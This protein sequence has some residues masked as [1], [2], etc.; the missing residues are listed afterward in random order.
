MATPIAQWRTMP[1]TRRTSSSDT[2]RVIV[3]AY[4]KIAPDTG[5]S[6]NEIQKVRF[7]VTDGNGTST[8]DVT[9]RTL[10]SPNDTDRTD[11]LPG[12]SGPG[13]APIWAFAYDVLMTRPAGPIYVGAT[14]Y[15][16][17]G[18]SYELPTTLTIYNHKNGGQ[19]PSPKEIYCSA[20]GSDSND[21][22][23]DGTP[24]KSIRKACELACTDNDAGGA[25]IY[26]TAGTHLWAWGGRPPGS[27]LAMITSDDFW[28]TIE[29]S[30]GV[31]RDDVIV[32]RQDP[33]DSSTWLNVTD[34]D[35]GQ[36]QFR[37][38]LRNVTIEGWG[39]VVQSSYSLAVYLWL[40]GCE[41][42]S[43]FASSIHVG[44]WETTSPGI[45]GENATRYVTGGYR[46]H[47]I[48]GWLGYEMVRGCR[49]S[50]FIGIALQNTASRQG[51][52]NL[53]V[54]TQRYQNGVTGWFDATTGLFDISV[55]QDGR[56]RVKA[57]NSSVPDFKPAAVN[58]VG[59]T[60]VG[61]R[62][63]GD[64]YDNNNGDYLVAEAGYEGGLP[65]VDLDHPDPKASSPASQITIEVVMLSW[66]T[67]TQYSEAIHPD[68][69]QINGNYTNYLFANVRA[70]DIDAAQ[71]IF[72]GTRMLTRYAFVNFAGGKGGLNSWFIGTNS[73]S[74]VDHV[75][76]RHITW[77]GTWHFE[78]DGNFAYSDFEVFDCAF[79]SAAYTPGSNTF[80]VDASN[81]HFQSGI[82]FGNSASHGSS[83]TFWA[84]SSYAS[85]GDYSA[86]TS[87]PGNHAAST[88]WARPPAYTY[89]SGTP[90]KG[91][92]SNTSVDGGW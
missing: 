83:P 20:S 14:V 25:T 76:M 80:N 71:G 49:I 52:C 27:A 84:D 81:I 35:I 59:L 1:G 26:L 8:Y 6:V 82:F 86:N 90:D 29:P 32:T 92:W 57:R 51:V 23:S 69:L 24:V 75:L 34:P 62:V 13:P 89:S 12:W 55:T 30:P 17:H 73:G 68:I 37:L 22:L 60:R 18:T 50:N 48:D 44:A 15:P 38:R 64:T 28:L 10:V 56:M 66:G 79:A 70:V 33:S 53:L 74:G 9:T 5:G 65:Y 46:H 67:W 58:L 91:A 2:V 41:E 4:H 47:V 19:P 63:S 7:T 21:G 61:L 42:R 39:P 40:D 85:T 72:A 78:R 36:Q 54:E 3:E 77:G 16:N 43:T 88:S 45:S 31:D 11:P 87:G